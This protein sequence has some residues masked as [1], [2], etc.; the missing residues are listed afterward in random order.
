ML[1]PIETLVHHILMLYI[2]FSPVALRAVDL[3]VNS[4]APGPSHLSK[5]LEQSD[6]DSKVSR[7]S[8]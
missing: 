5:Y 8:A 2:G 4:S 3:R 1:F 7:I 6:L